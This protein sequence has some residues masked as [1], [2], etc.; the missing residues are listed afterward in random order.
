MTITARIDNITSI[1]DVYRHP[2][3]PAPES[4]KIELTGRCNFAC[5]FCARSYKL[6]KQMDMDRQF[7]S[8][9][10]REM[11]DAGVQELGMF[12]LGE[13]F[14]LK[15]L[16]DAIAEAKQVGFPYVFC[17]TNGSLSNPKKVRACME[18]GLDSL[19][20]SYNYADAAQLEDIAGVKGRHFELI[21]KNIKAAWE[22]RE[23][24]G[25]DTGLYASYIEYDGAQAERMMDAVDEIRPY[26]DE[27][28]A[29]PLYNQADLVST[30]VARRDWRPTAGNRGRIGALR[31]GLP[32]WA[33]FTEGHITWDG[34]LS[35]CCFDHT[36]D[37]NMGDLN[38]LPFEE[39]WNSA[40]FQELRRRH[41]TK[42]VRGTACE[43]CVAYA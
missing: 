24:H 26:V 27:V 17:T 3:I 34:K 21:K 6:R 39:A 5:S 42:D 20:F 14:M 8:R 18:A 36:G 15:W 11:R 7:Y 28:Y 38:Q 29:L 41:L 37:F 16:P 31:E 35:A 43:S 22:V 12:Y 13:S 19:K 10:I 30:E 40:A 2:H 33:V 9:V 1:K 25:F 4:V 23:A 32:C